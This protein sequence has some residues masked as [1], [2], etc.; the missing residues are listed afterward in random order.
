M[1]LNGMI[2]DTGNHIRKLELKCSFLE[3]LVPS[4]YSPEYWNNLGSSMNRSGS[5]S[6]Q[7]QERQLK[8]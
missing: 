8:I 6:R 2:T 7:K 5:Y 4:K 3:R 1:Q